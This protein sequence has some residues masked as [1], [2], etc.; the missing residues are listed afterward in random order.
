MS[1]PERITSLQ[2]PRI[3]ALV[4]LRDRGG[5]DEAGLMLIEEARVIRRARDAGQAF[6][7]VYYCPEHLAAGDADDRVL[8]A[9]LRDGAADGGWELVEL[10]PPV[11]VK[12]SYRKR[13]EGLLVVAPQRPLGLDDLDLPAAPLLLV[14]ADV[15]KPGNLGAML[16]TADAAGVDAVLVCGGGA[17]LF[18]PNALRAST[19]ALFTVPTAAADADAVR[20]FLR[21][22]GLAVV[23]TTPDAGTTHVETDLTGPLALVLG[24]EDRGLDAAWLA[25]ADRRAR[26]PMRGRCDSLNVGVAAAVLLFEA[27]RQRSPAGPEGEPA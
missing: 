12:A 24:P 19:G 17:D 15:E 8:Y 11:M 7:A 26:I 20:A 10:A 3:K 13:P 23:A 4:K 16:R 27:L 5:R 25:A 22:R 6:A 14:L 1:E 18:N 21:D 9:E 2:N